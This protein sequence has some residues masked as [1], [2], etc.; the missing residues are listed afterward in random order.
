VLGLTGNNTGANTIGLALGDSAGAGSLL[1]VV[2]NGSGYWKLSGSNTYSGTTTVSN[3]TLELAATATDPVLVNANGANITRGRM[4]LDYSGS[5]NQSTIYNI[6]KASFNNN[7]FNNTSSRIRSTS[8]TT[9]KGLG[10]NDD[11]ANSRVHVAE[12]LYGDGDLSGGV[13]LTDFTFLAAN[14]NT[15]PTSDQWLKGDYNY[16]GG[17][18]L[19]DFTFLASNFNQTLP[20]AASAAA[21]TDA[22]SI[23]SVVP[24]PSTVA[25]TAAGVAGLFMRRRRR[26]A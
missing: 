20:A 4:I 11:A 14:F 25:M 7:G 24:E 6:L 15:F 9:P 10:W 1:A 21:G 8:A 26:T 17:V 2:K 22:G 18:D 3:G 13:D 5:S 19:T 12:A 23:G 16:D